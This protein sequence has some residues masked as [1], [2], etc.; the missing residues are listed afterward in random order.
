MSIGEHQNKELADI[1]STDT[2]L[3]SNEIVCSHL[4]DLL[5]QLLF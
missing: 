4:E 5:V 2:L 3:Y 1:Q